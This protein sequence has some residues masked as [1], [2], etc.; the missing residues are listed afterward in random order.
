MARS[1]TC[2]VGAYDHARLA[3]KENTN[4]QKETFRELNPFSSLARL[5]SIVQATL[6]TFMYIYV[7]VSIESYVTER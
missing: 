4:V 3:T 7:V 1:I 5:L 2:N 6:T